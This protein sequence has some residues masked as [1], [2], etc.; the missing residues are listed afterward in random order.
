MKLVTRDLAD[1]IYAKV[2]EWFEDKTESPVSVHVMFA[3]AQS[4][5]RSAVAEYIANE[6]GYT[7]Y[8]GRVAE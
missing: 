3:S 5:A 8:E 7:F 1:E 2:Y 4:C 6:I